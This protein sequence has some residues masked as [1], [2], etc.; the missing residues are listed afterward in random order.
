MLVDLERV[1]RLLPDT[2]ISQLQQAVTQNPQLNFI[3]AL[4][5]G[6]DRDIM[7]SPYA[8]YNFLDKGNFQLALRE[9]EPSPQ[10]D[11]ILRLAAAS[12]GAPNSVVEDALNLDIDRGID[13]A[14][15]FSAIG[16]EMKQKR[17]IE[18]YKPILRNLFRE[19]TDTILQFIESIE[20]GQFNES[21]KLMSTGSIQFKGLL[22]TLATVALGKKAPKKWR[23]YARKLLFLTE[24]PFLKDV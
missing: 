7:S 23:N 16:L 12:D 5:H 22:C 8:G 17:D 11:N 3:L 10:T 9:I 18:K 15:I 14:T 24:K 13:Q 1:N 6:S 2:S 19:Q 20:K 4:E 21:E